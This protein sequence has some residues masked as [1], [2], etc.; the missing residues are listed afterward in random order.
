MSHHSVA[1]RLH[2]QLLQ[3]ITD[4][5]PGNR[6]PSEPDLAEQL[7]V[8]RATL[9]EAMRAFETQGVIRR[10]QG[11][12][13]YV[14]Q[15]PQVLESGLEVLESIE[16]MAQRSGL[17]VDFGALNLET[18]V[19]D[20]DE[21]PSLAAHPG[22]EVLCISRVIL[23]EARPVAYLVDTLPAGLV[24][25]DELQA[26][27]RGSILDLLLQR[28]QPPLLAS[29]TEISAVTA[30][31]RVARA[32]GIQRGDVLLC[33]LAELYT[34]NRQVID[35]SQSYFLPG[36]FRFHVVRRLVHRTDAPG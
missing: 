26:D 33:F 14:N 36:Y 8:S 28:G 30:T 1:Q 10:K 32:L 15:P 22:G 17:T 19:P 24:S 7:K 9:R 20:S 16:T 25:P 5:P 31:P 21:C 23:A 4:T 3:I 2:D 6:L 27:F 12:G 18:R 34:T 13:T 35:R 11:S 29:R